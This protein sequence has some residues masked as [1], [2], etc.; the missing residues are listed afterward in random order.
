MIIKT[1]RIPCIRAERIAEYFDSQ[2]SNE[3]TQWLRGQSDALRLMCEASKLA[4][5]VFGVR[6]VI[7]APEVNMPH[8]DLG[9]VLD[10]YCLE[11]NVP[12]SSRLIACFVE[13][14]KPRNGACGTALHWHI[15]L[16]EVDTNLGTLDSRFTRIRDEKIA[17][18]CEL[19]L[20]HPPVVG[21]FDRQVYCWLKKQRTELL[22]PVAPAQINPGETGLNHNP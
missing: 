21:K 16:P 2:G 3:R 13:H 15:A 18:I 4:G 11:Y 1:K 9:L 22:L 8:R 7:V 6:H 19:R 5:R 17:R 12:A 14:Q 10:E 20:G